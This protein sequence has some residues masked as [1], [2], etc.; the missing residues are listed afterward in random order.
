MGMGTSHWIALYADLGE[1]WVMQ[2]L[3]RIEQRATQFGRRFRPDI[4]A[5]LA[6]AARLRRGSNSAEVPERIEHYRLSH[7]RRA[8]I[9]AVEHCSRLGPP[10]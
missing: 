3:A 6:R 9:E 4:G 10:C 1:T 8:T 2:Q 5:L 7:L